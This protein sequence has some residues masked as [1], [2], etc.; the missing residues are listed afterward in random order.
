M[1]A[2]VTIAERTWARD[3]ARYERMAYGRIR[4]AFRDI[5]LSIPQQNLNKAMYSAAIA[6]N[7][8]RE[9]II[10]ALE[11]VWLPIA[12]E[13]W[14]AQNRSIA[15]K[16]GIK[17]DLPPERLGRIIRQYIRRNRG[18]SIDS[19]VA[20]FTAYLVAL[21]GELWDGADTMDSVIAAFKAY[22]IGELF[23]RWQSARIARTEATAAANYGRH[24]AASESGFTLKKT[25]MTMLDE[26]VRDNAYPGFSHAM[27]HGFTIPAN[28]LFT[29]NGVSLRFPGDPSAQPAS[30]AAG[31]IINCRCM[32]VYDI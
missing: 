8:D 16:I 13:T 24:V 14:G 28:Q 7:V 4:M 29:Q 19:M 9:R 1:N 27:L 26:R 15:E 21:V 31:M 25:W 3:H 10:S 11:S 18:R 6:A 5:A 12:A 17:Q 22:L 23:Y 30:R 32:L 20:G 2:D